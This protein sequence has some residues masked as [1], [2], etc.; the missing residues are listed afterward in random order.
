MGS[1]ITEW[2]NIYLIHGSFSISM[3]FFFHFFHAILFFCQT[4]LFPLLCLL[5]LFF[6]LPLSFIRA[7][8][9]QKWEKYVNSIYRVWTFI[10]INFACKL[11]SNIVRFTNIVFT[12]SISK[13]HGLL[14]E[15]TNFPPLIILSRPNSRATLHTLLVQHW[16]WIEWSLF[17]SFSPST[18]RIWGVNNA[19]MKNTLPAYT[20]ICIRNTLSWEFTTS[21]RIRLQPLGCLCEVWCSL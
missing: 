14:F 12:S 15:W 20:T 16:I 7:E 4:W 21:L 1:S 8:F 18:F 10:F 6:S 2:G 13:F 19:S 9:N 3:V 17:Y 11:F 5:Y